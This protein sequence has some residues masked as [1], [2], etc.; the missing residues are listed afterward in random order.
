MPCTL[1]IAPILS[2]LKS[3]RHHKTTEYGVKDKFSSS[4]RLTVKRGMNRTAMAVI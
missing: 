3:R 2:T 1:T 4:P